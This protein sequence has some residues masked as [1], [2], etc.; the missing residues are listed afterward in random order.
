[1][2][3]EGD[4]YIIAALREN[5]E[6]LLDLYWPGWI[7]RGDSGYPCPEDGRDLGSFQV[8][9]KGARRGDWF[10]NS[11]GVGGGPLN[12]IAYGLTGDHKRY[13]E[14][15]K[16]AK[17]FLGIE[18]RVDRE[19]AARARKRSSE[20]HQASE[21]RQAKRSESIR[22]IAF[23]I[24]ETGVPIGGTVAEQYL[25]KRGIQI[26]LGFPSLR[27]IDALGYPCDLGHSAGD[28]WPALVCAVQGPDMR[29]RGLWRIYLTDDGEKAPY[30]NVKFGLG[31]CDP[32]A[33]WFGRP[34]KVVNVCE[35]VETALA[36]RSILEGSQP[37]CAARSTSGMM[38]FKPPAAVERV[39]IWPDGDVD[40]IRNEKRLESPGLKAARG[41]NERMAAAGVSCSIQP[42]PQTGRDYL[43]AWNAI[44][45]NGE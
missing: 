39:L 29:F 36:V 2:K 1:M 32:G 12:L 41:L 25:R 31:P 19:A 45:G 16:A 5:L 4:D 11:E 37:V 9:L 10:R 24:W 38:N 42:T 17:E 26:E 33:V 34:G 44:K 30:S 7:A 40:K 20:I 28:R 35:G 27:F 23:R 14:A 15:F 3:R 43:D 8:I 13:N 18:G 22:D 6:G 21:K